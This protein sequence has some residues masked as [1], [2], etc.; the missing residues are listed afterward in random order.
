MPEQNYMPKTILIV[1]DDTFLRA[2][3]VKKLNEEGFQIMEAMDGESAINQ[4]K[5][6]TPDL[7]LLDLILPGMDGFEILKHIKKNESSSSIPVI[8]LSNLGQ[9][10][11]IDRGLELGAEDFLIKAHFTPDEIIQ[12]VRSVLKG[13]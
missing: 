5:E 7:I 2:L 4:L 6:K 12:K 11:E 13:D 3:I 10:E 9:K 1:E 8:I